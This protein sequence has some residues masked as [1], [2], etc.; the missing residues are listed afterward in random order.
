M[1]PTACSAAFWLALAIA[2]FARGLETGHT[3]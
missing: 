2:S 3:E 1:V